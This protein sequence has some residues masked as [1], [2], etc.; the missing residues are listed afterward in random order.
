MSKT[1][2]SR[3]CGLKCGLLCAVENKGAWCCYE[4]NLLLIKSKQ[5]LCFKKK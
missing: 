4:Y 1:L 3:K 5:H 2:K